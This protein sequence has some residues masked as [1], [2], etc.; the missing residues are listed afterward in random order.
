[1]FPA[2][3]YACASHPCSIHSSSQGLQG[4]ES[5]VYRGPQAARNMSTTRE[6]PGH[7]KGGCEGE[8]PERTGIDPLGFHT[9]IIRLHRSGA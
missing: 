1:M 8:G 4:R 7:R 9:V 5:R 2:D 3:R 6:K